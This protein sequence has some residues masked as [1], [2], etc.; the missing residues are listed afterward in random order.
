MQGR[1][2]GARLTRAVGSIAGAAAGS[3]RRLP[4]ASNVPI[5][6]NVVTQALRPRRSLLAFALRLRNNAGYRDWGVNGTR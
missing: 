3:A 6:G 4:V 1:R 5:Q 2:K